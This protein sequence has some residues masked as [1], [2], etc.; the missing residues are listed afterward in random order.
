M[1]P[2]NNPCDNWPPPQAEQSSDSFNYR[3]GGFDLSMADGALKFTP[4]WLRTLTV[5]AIS[6]ALG[7]VP[8]AYIGMIV[9]ELS[10]VPHSQIHN[11]LKFMLSMAFFRK[12]MPDLIVTWAFAPVCWLQYHFLI[13][14]LTFLISHDGTIV[15]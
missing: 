11:T 4:I 1:T 12:L 9:Y 7:V 5:L 14:S 15:T 6:G 2:V 3:D 8:I 10:S 13:K